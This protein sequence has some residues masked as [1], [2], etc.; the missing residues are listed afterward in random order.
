MEQS[1]GVSAR[2]EEFG[3][4]PSASRGTVS[5][6]GLSGRELAASA[7]SAKWSR[8]ESTFDASRA[9]CQKGV[10]KGWNWTYY[11]GTEIGFGESSEVPQSTGYRKDARKVRPTA[12]RGAG[13][14]H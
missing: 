7:P 1:V 8:T 13:F 10:E 6:V 4:Y 12:C 2:V 5:L 14:L 9:Q 11:I 3:C